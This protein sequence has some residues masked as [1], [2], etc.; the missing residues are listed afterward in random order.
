M[1][2]TG[3]FLRQQLKLVM[4]DDALSVHESAEDP[5]A[6]REEVHPGCTPAQKEADPGGSALQGQ[7][8]EDPV[9]DS[10]AVGSG[11]DR[12]GRAAVRSRSGE[13]GH[14]PRDHPRGDRKGQISDHVQP[15]DGDGRGVLYGSDHPEPLQNRADRQSE[16]DQEELRPDQSAPQGGG[17]RSGDHPGVRHYH[18]LG[19]RGRVPAAPERRRSVRTASGEAGRR[20][21]SRSYIRLPRA[22]AARDLC[23]EGRGTA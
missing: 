23:R 11:A 17:Q 3:Q 6:G 21:H 9:Y 7:S 8:A 2:S 15:P 10:A 14:H 18:T 12:P 19:K 20:A 1:K 4:E 5:H 13:Y 22:F 16:R